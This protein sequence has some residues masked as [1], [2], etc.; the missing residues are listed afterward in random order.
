MQLSVFSIK[1]KKANLFN[2]PFAVRTAAEAMRSVAQA[3][4]D[5]QTSLGSFPEDFALYLVAHFDDD[6]G[7]MHVPKEPTR[8]EEISNLIRSAKA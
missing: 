3:A 2:Q 4:Q 7:V 8:I 1:D 6:T 5:A